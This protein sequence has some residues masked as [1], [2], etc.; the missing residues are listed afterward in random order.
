[1]LEVS[2]LLPLEMMMLVESEIIFVPERK[3][4]VKGSIV[5]ADGTT[6]AT[7]DCLLSV[8]YKADVLLRRKKPDRYRSGFLR[9][10]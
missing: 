9:R 1:M 7:A 6:Y 10:P 5:S 3:I 8:F 4:K 2:Q